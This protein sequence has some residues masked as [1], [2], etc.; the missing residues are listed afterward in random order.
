MTEHRRSTRHDLAVTA[1]VL[2][3]GFLYEGRTLNLSTG[4]VNVVV[5]EDLPAGTLV[6]L[7]LLL[8]LDGVEHAGVEPIDL[9]AHVVWT[10]PTET[11]GFMVGLRF[12]ALNDRQQT[13]IAAL[14]E[15]CQE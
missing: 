8:T 1:E 2:H 11:E 5:T 6:Q 14:I 13:H 7:T 15:P 12:A 3:A 9:P 4:G 10:A